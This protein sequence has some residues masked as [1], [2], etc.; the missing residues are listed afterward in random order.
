MTKVPTHPSSNKL[1]AP[2]SRHP[3]RLK[4]YASELARPARGATCH[5]PSAGRDEREKRGE[6]GGGR[7]GSKSGARNEERERETERRKT[8]EKHAAGTRRQKRERGGGRR[9]RADGGA[10]SGTQ[11]SDDRGSAGAGKFASFRSK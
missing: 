8:T 1:V 6:H 10:R 2:P 7:S 11:E 9:R 5:V 3:L 4:S